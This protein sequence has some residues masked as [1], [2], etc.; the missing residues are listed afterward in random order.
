MVE[1]LLSVVVP[2]Y[3]EQE[4]LPETHRRLTSVLEQIER[5]N[6]EIV[7]VDDGSKDDSPGMLRRMQQ[8]DGHV[9]VLQFSRNFGH[10]IAITAGIEHCCG[11][12]VVVI[13]ADL[14][15]PPE[16][17]PEM[18]ER[19]RRGADV[20]Y[21]TRRERPDESTFK[22]WTAKAFYRI[23]NSLSDIPIPLDSGDFRLMNRRA[24]NSLLAMPERDRFVRGMVAWVGFRQEPVFYNRSGRFAGTTKYPLSKMIRFATDGIISFS[25][26]PLRIASWVGFTAAGLAFAGILY[27][28]IMRLVTDQW[29]PG[30]TLLFIALLFMGGIQLVFLGIIGQY[31][32]RVYGEVKRRPLYIVSERIGFPESAAGQGEGR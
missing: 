18:I 16:L 17:I 5:L 20:V 31:L 26:V 25:F 12:A 22:R 14:Q 24:V 1:S 7:Y 27:A 8:D 23:I 32:G 30:W 6:Y 19:W 29:V 10:Q 2:C 3:N 9:R 28:L 13:D 11:D 15:D 4:S 21:G